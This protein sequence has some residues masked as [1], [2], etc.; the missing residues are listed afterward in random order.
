MNIAGA[1]NQA[2]AAAAYAPGMLLTITGS[3]LAPT[4]AKASD[5]PINL[6]MAGVSATVNGISAPLSALS[7]GQL[8]IQIPFEAGSGAAVLGV[9][10]NGQI[11]SYT[12]QMAAS[13]PGIFTDPT[14]APAPFGSGEAGKPTTVFIT[15]E[16]DVSPSLLTG[17]T[18]TSGTPQSRLPQPLLPVTV[19]VGGLP[20][21]VSFAGIT[22]GL[23]GESQVNFTIPPGVSPGPQPVVV[24]VG[25][26]PSPPA[27][28]TV[29]PPQ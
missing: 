8:T 27:T 21:V 25:G 19:T 2:S 1:A 20:A 16:G 10:N 7:P 15:G 22:S 29:N 4:T 13:A 3:G 18:P 26:V 5:P 28:L 23:V 11:A 14:G 9:N 6:S 12:F 24:T 17:T